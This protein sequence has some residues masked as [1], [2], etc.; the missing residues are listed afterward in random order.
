[1]NLKTNKETVS[2]NEKP[3]VKIEK[4]LANSKQEKFFRVLRETFGQG[5]I[6]SHLKKFT[7]FVVEKVIKGDFNELPAE[8]RERWFKRVNRI[9]VD[10]LGGHAELGWK[11]EYIEEQKKKKEEKKRAMAENRDVT[12]EEAEETVTDYLDGL[13]GRDFTSD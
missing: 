12:D 7:I 1:M 3:P 11:K 5:D 6:D 8:E 13:L 4:T 9:I 2:Q 10:K